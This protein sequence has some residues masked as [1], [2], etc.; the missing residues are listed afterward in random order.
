MA[1][2]DLKVGLALGSGGARGFAHLGVLERL[3]E[4]NI[5]IDCI[6]GTSMGSL[7]G[8]VYACGA[9]LKYL[10][11]LAEE[12]DWNKITDVT[13]PRLGLI[14]GDKLLSLLKLLTKEK[15]F[16]S[17]PVSFAAI[18]CD[19][20]KGEKV[21]IDE[22][23]VA[24]AIRA[25]CSIPGVFLPYEYGERRLVDGAIV[26]RVPAFTVKEMGADVIIAVDLGVEKVNS[27]VNNIFDVIINTFNIMQME[28]YNRNNL[29]ADIIIEPE[30]KGITTYD[31]DKAERAIKAGY[32]AADES[33]EKINMFFQEEIL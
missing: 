6:A 28:C 7:I 29:N 18:C 22:G 32:R 30:L 31:L 3:E 11:G 19:I 24:R 23:S 20:E 8:G 33:M 9:P 27:S 2:N 26:N 10:K 4:E 14:K 12:I 21:V 13:F 25:S 16:S 1:N 15:N 5:E 17:L